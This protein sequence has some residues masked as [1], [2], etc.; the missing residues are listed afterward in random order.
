MPFALKDPEP[1]GGLRIANGQARIPEIKH[2]GGIGGVC[3]HLLSAPILQLCLKDVIVALVSNARAA[4]V[5]AWR[6]NEDFVC[7]DDLRGK[8]GLRP[9]IRQRYLGSSGLATLG[10][11]CQ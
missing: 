6:G 1:D 2:Q 7:R 8:R 9:F 5:S 11:D 3:N 4:S 10:V